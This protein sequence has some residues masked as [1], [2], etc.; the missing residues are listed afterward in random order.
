MPLKQ[1]SIL[2]TRYG[3]KTPENSRLS[4]AKLAR[5]TCAKKTS[6]MK[7]RRSLFAPLSLTQV[8]I[9]KFFN[10]TPCVTVQVCVVKEEQRASTPELIDL[11]E[12]VRAEQLDQIKERFL[13]HVDSFVMSVERYPG[14]CASRD[15]PEAVKEA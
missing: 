15:F 13:R 5:C 6:A 11:E 7:G 14:Y 12:K 1:H 4:R 8:N 10:D 2:A 9:E 3:I